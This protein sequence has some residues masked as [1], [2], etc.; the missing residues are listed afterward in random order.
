MDGSPHARDNQLR[1]LAELVE[2][3]VGD[4][5]LV[6]EPDDNASEEGRAQLGCPNDERRDRGETVRVWVDLR[7]ERK[8]GVQLRVRAVMQDRELNHVLR[9]RKSVV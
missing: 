3:D 7:V 2:A 9:D 5:N 4:V 8:E 6:R 1:V